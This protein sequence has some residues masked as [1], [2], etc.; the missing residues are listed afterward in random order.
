[1]L[2]ASQVV[3]DLMITIQLTLTQAPAMI[4]DQTQQETTQAVATASQTITLN[5]KATWMV[6]HATIE[7]GPMARSFGSS[8]VSHALQFNKQVAVQAQLVNALITTV[9]AQIGLTESHAMAGHGQLVRLIGKSVVPLAP[10]FKKKQLAQTS[11]L[12]TTVNAR[13]GLTESHVMVD[14]GPQEKHIGKNVVPLA[15]LFRMDLEILETLTAAMVK[16]TIIHN[17]QATLMVSLVMEGPGPQVK[18]I[19]KNVASH[20]SQFNQEALQQL[21]LQQTM[22][23]TGATELPIPIQNAQIMLMEKLVT[24]ADGPMERFSGKNAAFLV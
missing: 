17:V 18:P 21:N 24:T 5:V 23:Q 3:L 19:G 15:P 11:A 7:D 2:I 6:K 8:V 13:I 1:M 22:S 20:A 9:N 10:P 16:L 4:Q 12:I 14:P